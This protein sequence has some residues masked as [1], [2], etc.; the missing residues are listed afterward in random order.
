MIPP[1]L[2]HI[3]QPSYRLDIDGLRGFQIFALMAFHYFPTVITGG[4]IGV[5]IF[6]VISGYLITSIL[7][8]SLNSNSFNL[9]EFMMRRCQRIFPALIVILIAALSI[10]WLYL[11]SGEFKD[12]GRL[13]TASS[14]F[15]ANFFAWNEVNYFSSSAELNPLLHLW[16]LGIE[17][18]FYL[19]WPVLLWI[20]WKSKVNF[21]PVILLACIISFTLNIF[22]IHYDPIEAFYAPWTRFWEI[23]SGG[24]LSYVHLY[25]PKILDKKYFSLKNIGNYSSILGLF[26]LSYGVIFFTKVTVFPGWNA[27]VPIIGAILLLGS[28]PNAWVNKFLLSNQIIVW[29]GIIS[30]PLYL[31]HWML[32]SYTRLI[33]GAEP[34]VMEKLALLALSVLLAWLTY[35]FIENP[36]RLASKAKAKSVILCGILVLIGFAGLIINEMN[37]FPNRAVNQNIE[38]YAASMLMEEEQHNCFDIPYAYKRKDNWFCEL[39]NNNAKADFFVYGDSHATSLYP[40]F[41]TISYRENIKILFS[42]LSECPPLMGIQPV[43]PVKYLEKHNCMAL[44]NRIYEYIKENKIKNVI[45]VSRWTYYTK[46]ISRPS[47][48]ILIARNSS[49]KT[50]EDTSKSNLEFS[51]KNTVDA[52][53]KIGVNVFIIEDT[54]QQTILPLKLLKLNSKTPYDWAINKYSIKLEEHTRNQDEVNTFINSTGA[55]IINFDKLLCPKGICKF[56]EDGKFL[57]FDDD[58]LSIYGAQKTIPSLIRVFDRSIL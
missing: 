1:P 42:G 23:L 45:L 25:R 4:Y 50:D 51:I 34:P 22:S 56:V 49:D 16:S 48:I 44:N 55:F 6:F 52:F 33:T 43:R 30:Y 14:I 57:Y 28:G 12:L 29:F 7:L 15:S 5:S 27:L 35:K 37:G 2:I 13:I 17:E 9:L 18:Q 46:S 39:G 19:F 11:L 38:R 24:V 54:P 36:I 47:E 20:A 10:G 21:F 32:L 53:K 31:W 8:K 3:Y 40:A 58:H 26:I 41:S